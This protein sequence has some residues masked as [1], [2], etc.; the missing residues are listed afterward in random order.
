MAGGIRSVWGQ[1]RNTD[2]LREER[3]SLYASKQF[4]LKAVFTDWALGGKGLKEAVN[5][6]STYYITAARSHSE[7]IVIK[8]WS[9]PFDVT[10]RR[11][12]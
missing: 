8:V 6:T 2:T 11:R 7:V 10:S 3:L 9:Q 1:M 4:N 12:S 5:P